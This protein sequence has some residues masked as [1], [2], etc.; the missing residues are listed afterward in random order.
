[1][2]PTKEDPKSSVIWEAFQPQ[3]EPRR[4]YN[5]AAG[6]PYSSQ[7]N[8]QQALQ[9]RLKQIEEM[10]RRGAVPRTAAPAATQPAPQSQPQTPAVLPTQ[11]AL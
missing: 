9:E 2:F 6:D 3:T 8:Y 7:Q 4:S 5:S 11:N 1:M 10:K